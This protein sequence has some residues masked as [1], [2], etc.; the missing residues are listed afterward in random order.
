MSIRI[1]FPNAD[2]ELEENN[3]SINMPK[4]SIAKPCDLSRISVFCEDKVSINSLESNYVPQRFSCGESEREYEI[5]DDFTY[6]LTTSQKK[7]KI[8]SFVESIST[9]CSFEKKN[10]INFGKNLFDDFNKCSQSQE[11]Y[12]LYNIV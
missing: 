1:T 7:E 10:Q 8:N 6:K 12:F 11:K 3:C 2:E 5:Q 9:R 4:Q